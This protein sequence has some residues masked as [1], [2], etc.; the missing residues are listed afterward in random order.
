MRSNG[1]CSN[2]LG[3]LSPAQVI[4]CFPSEPNIPAGTEYGQL[5]YKNSSDVVEIN[6]LPQ[7]HDLINTMI[8]LV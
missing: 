1:K 5:C 3:P 4:F 6:C 8:A 2:S 7:F